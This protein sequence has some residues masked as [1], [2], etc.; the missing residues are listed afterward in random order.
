MTNDR[1][2][3]ILIVTAYEKCDAYFG[4]GDVFGGCGAEFGT[5]YIERCGAIPSDPRRGN[6]WEFGL[7]PRQSG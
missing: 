4:V 7:Y 2:T 6:G 3:A 5:G 1:E